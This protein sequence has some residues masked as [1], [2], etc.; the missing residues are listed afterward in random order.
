LELEWPSGERHGTLR[1]DDQG[2]PFRTSCMSGRPHYDYPLG[3]SEW[4][5]SESG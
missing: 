4:I 1:I 3:G 2:K 5:P